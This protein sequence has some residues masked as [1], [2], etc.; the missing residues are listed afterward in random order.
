MEKR[1][2]FIS[3]CLLILVTSGCAF[4]VHETPLNYSY[5]GQIGK[6]TIQNPKKTLSVGDFKDNRDVTTPKI[7]MNMRN[8]NGFRTTGGW[9][10]EKPINEI[11]KDAL[12]QGI[13]MTGLISTNRGD[14]LLTGEIIDYSGEIRQKLFASGVFNSKLTVKLQ[15]REIGTEKVIWR[16][17]F[18]GQ[19]STESN[20]YIKE[21]FIL[22]LNDLVTKVCTDEF[23]LQ[24]F[25]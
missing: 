13:K 25:K 2:V 7:I 8:A 4:S 9:E 24:H 22:A 14:L 23:F 3:L 20:D 19:A 18:I 10:A 16:D 21:G 11:V 15:L 12:S 6:D 17:T 1:K 5:S